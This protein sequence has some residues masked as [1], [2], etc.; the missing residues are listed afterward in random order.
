MN[1]TTPVPSAGELVFCT[2]CRC[3]ERYG[4]TAERG[5]TR[6]A[7]GYLCPEDSSTTPPQSDE[8]AAYKAAVSKALELMESAPEAFL[9]TAS[10]NLH[11]AAQILR[12]AHDTTSTRSLRCQHCGDTDGPFKGTTADILCEACIERGGAW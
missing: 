8:L 1:A 9:S 6:H 7:G 11:A 3:G 12:D 10:S 5:W 2:R 4:K